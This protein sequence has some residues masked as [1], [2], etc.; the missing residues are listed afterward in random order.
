M[1]AVSLEFG[2]GFTVVTGETGAGKSVLLGALSLL[3]GNRAEKTLIRQGADCCEVEALIHL[4]DSAGVDASLATFGLPACEDGVLV[5]ARSLHRSRAP[6]IKVNG[7]LATLSVLRGL[8]G[9]WIDFHGPGEPQKLFQE[10]RQLEMLDLFAGCAADTEAYAAAY[11][12][13]RQCLQDH[14]ALKRSGGLS[15]DEEDFIRGQLAK[16]EALDLTAESIAALE[17][18]FA[19]V[20]RSREL[21]AHAEALEQGLRG[22]DGVAGGLAAMLRHARALADID[23]HAQALLGRLET[24]AI[25][26]DDIAG[27]CATIANDCQFDEAAVREVQD[28][29]QAWME[30]KRK[31]GPDPESVREKAAALRQRLE[32][33]TDVE[34][35]LEALLQQ[36]AAQE[37]DLRGRAADLRK[38]RQQAAV[39]LAERTRGILGKL[40]FRKAGFQIRVVP[41]AELGPQGDCH[42]VF[43]FAPNPGV[44]P[45]PL[46][47]IASSGETARVMLALKTVLAGMDRTPLLVFDEVDANV[48][49]EIGAEVGRELAALAS[50]HQV[51]CVTHLPQVAAWGQ[52]HLQVD[53][54]QTD[55]RAKVTI[56]SITDN[57]AGRENEL[58]RMLGD[59]A[60]SS[61][62]SHAR[63]LL[64]KAAKPVLAETRQGAA[65]GKPRGGRKRAAK[66]GG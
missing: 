43:L 8:A 33:Q 12:G 21:A 5:L 31:Y 29:M 34:S 55:T 9:D 59:R 40:G 56:E 37:R 13:W 30:L 2:A 32:S 46:N 11:R 62:L 20:S 14:A 25:E 41:D 22:D 27:D 28:R 3:A 10:S 18:D 51:L 45:L 54:V 63:E 4:A 57:P 26:V 17:R 64:E 39:A 52:G 15:A 38:S 1:D 50:G 66:K 24:L 48:G 35:R 7:A 44:D 23:P 19:R 65:A 53:K 47:K 16:L 61:A 58:A 6:V 49:G 36:A 60:S 42:C